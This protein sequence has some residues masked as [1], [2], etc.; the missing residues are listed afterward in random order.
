MNFS[1][2]NYITKV[3]YILTFLIKISIFLIITI[4][5][6]EIGLRLSGRLKTP[7]EKNFNTYQ[8]FY[9]SNLDSHLYKWKENNT[10]TVK[11]REFTN[12]YSTNKY[13]FLDKKDIKRG[14]SI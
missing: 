11:Q 3:T 7:S 9:E 12:S 13:G 10:T 5:I 14:L 8:S 2:K 1:T 6:L 4:L